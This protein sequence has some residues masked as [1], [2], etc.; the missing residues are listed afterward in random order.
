MKRYNFILLMLICPYFVFSQN[1][2]VLGGIK[3]NSVDVNYGLVKNV[4]NPI[5]D[6]D[7]ATKAYV[8]AAN[9]SPIYSIGLSAEQGG[10]I[11]WI[12]LDGKHG[13]VAETKNQAAGSNW[14]NA[15]NPISNPSTHSVNGA[16]FRDWRLPT[17]FELNEMYLQKED[18]GDLYGY[19]YWSSSEINESNSWGQ[20]FGEEIDESQLNEE[21]TFSG[22]IRSVRSF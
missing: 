19:F 10:Y 14:Y 6:Q 7:A 11:F 5:S 22:D 18:I 17:K 20:N 8:D 16:K 12:S 4:A 3:A 13:L 21:K 15:Q 2:E 1:V 9:S